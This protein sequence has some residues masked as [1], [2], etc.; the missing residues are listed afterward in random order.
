MP[1]GRWLYNKKY[2]RDKRK[3]NAPQQRKKWNA[4]E[5][6][7]DSAKISDLEEEY[8]VN[9]TVGT[10]DRL[11]DARPWRGNTLVGPEQWVSYQAMLTFSMLESEE[12]NDFATFMYCR[13]NEP[14]TNHPKQLFD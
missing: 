2:G 5:A 7:V 14:D 12:L 1:R 4:D 11:L 8:F 9:P 13:L 10:A 3:Y 6:N